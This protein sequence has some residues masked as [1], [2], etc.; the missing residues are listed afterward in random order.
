MS[1]PDTPVGSGHPISDNEILEPEF[2]VNTVPAQRI[3]IPTPLDR[4][5][6]GFL[7]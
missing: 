6:F 1:D 7:H 3:G 2:P 4:K 5:E